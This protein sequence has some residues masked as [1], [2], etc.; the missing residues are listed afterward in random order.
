LVLGRVVREES[1]SVLVTQR[2][3]SRDG[4]DTSSDKGDGKSESHSGVCIVGGITR[5]G[6]VMEM[7]EVDR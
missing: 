7:D 4:A 6:G 3:G 1:G 2:C 5:K